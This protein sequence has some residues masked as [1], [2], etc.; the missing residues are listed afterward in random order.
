MMC[1]ERAKARRSWLL[2]GSTAAL[3]LAC[4]PAAR[5]AD[6]AEVSELVVTGRLEETQPQ[7]L[8][9]FGYHLEV[10]TEETIQNGLY[11]DVSQVLTNR[12]PGLFSVSQS[13]PF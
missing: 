13:G 10:V 6:A 2:A 5:A 8:S 11:V 7:A 9:K 4:A 3:A 1:A 12:V